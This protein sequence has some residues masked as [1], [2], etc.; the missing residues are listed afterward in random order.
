MQIK[1]QKERANTT[2]LLQ[3]YLGLNVQLQMCQIIVTRVE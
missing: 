1:I 2:P 3:Y